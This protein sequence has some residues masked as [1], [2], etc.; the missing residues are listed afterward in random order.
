VAASGGIMFPPQLRQIFLVEE[1]AFAN[2]AVDIGK[3]Q[4]FVTT[5]LFVAAFVSLAVNEIGTA[6]VASGVTALPAVTTSLVG[7][8]GISHGAYVL[9]KIPTSA[10]TPEGLSVKDRNGAPGVYNIKKRAA[11]QAQ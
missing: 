8:Y 10:G 7:L 2:Q 11:A 6:G 9:G 3:F 1:G 4:A 5:I